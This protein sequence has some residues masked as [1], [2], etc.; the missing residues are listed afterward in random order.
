MVFHNALFVCAVGAKVVVEPEGR[1]CTSM[2]N[3]WLAVVKF[4]GVSS[5]ALVTI[6]ELQA[7]ISAAGPEV[8]GTNYNY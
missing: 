7:H 8:I 2:V 5:A 3:N 1:I 6:P 4:S